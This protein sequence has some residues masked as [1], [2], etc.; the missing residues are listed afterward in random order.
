MS[1]S[2]SDEIRALR[3]TLEGIVPNKD[4][5]IILE[6]ENEVNPVQRFYGL[7]NNTEMHLSDMK[8]KIPR[9][10][11]MLENMKDQLDEESRRDIEEDL[12]KLKS[13]FEE[14]INSNGY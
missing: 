2:T 5:N 7:Y 9:L 3:E 6:M 1:R 11:S 4:K 8:N 14:V 13:L 12:N 10:E